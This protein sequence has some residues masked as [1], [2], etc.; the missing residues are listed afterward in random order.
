MTNGLKIIEKDE[1]LVTSSIEVAEI[2]EKRHADLLRSIGKYED[3]LLNSNLSSVDF[4]IKGDYLDV[5][6]RII[7][8]YFLTRKG[9][10]M[11]TNKMTGEKGVLFTA[12]YVERFYEME[13]Q[14]KQEL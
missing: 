13:N 5:T 14:L 3:I 1:H 6:G 11:I 4:F 8:C 12:T 7:P 9:C 10:D 2:I